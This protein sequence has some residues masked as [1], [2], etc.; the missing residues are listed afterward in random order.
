MSRSF[1]QK[2]AGE[3]GP[4]ANA[5]HCARA[6]LVVKVFSSLTMRILC[7][8]GPEGQAGNGLEELC[9]LLR[10]KSASL[11]VHPNH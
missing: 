5:V 4:Q 2:V 6:K 1:S 11:P 7:G 8:C 3:K 10:I 9:Y